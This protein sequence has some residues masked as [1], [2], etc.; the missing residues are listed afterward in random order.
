MTSAVDRAPGVPKVTTGGR[1]AFP[2][3]VVW[4]ELDTYAAGRWVDHEIAYVRTI[5]EGL[6]VC[7][8]HPPFRP[9]SDETWLAQVLGTSSAD[10]ESLALDAERRAEAST[11]QTEREDWLRRAQ[12]W[13][14]QA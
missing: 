3:R 10:C 9:E 13:W 11:D 12:S 14:G 4:R 5:R 1:G 8:Q 2:F 7:G 6:D